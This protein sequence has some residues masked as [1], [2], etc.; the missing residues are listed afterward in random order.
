M[1]LKGAS[2]ESHT[3]KPPYVDQITKEKTEE[4]TGAL[5]DSIL[6][7]PR[8]RRPILMS[9]HLHFIQLWHSTVLPE[10]RSEL[11]SDRAE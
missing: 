9:I 7:V 3:V 1:S 10:S 8:D 4:N 6:C 5:D 2:L 11:D